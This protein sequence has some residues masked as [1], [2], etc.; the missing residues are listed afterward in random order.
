MC[1]PDKRFVKRFCQLKSFFHLPEKHYLH[2]LITTSHKEEYCDS[3]LSLEIQHLLLIIAF[4]FFWQF[5]SIYGIYSY[6]FKK[7]LVY[8]KECPRSK[9]NQ[10]MHFGKMG[11]FVWQIE[12][13]IVYLIFK[14]NV[15]N[16]KQSLIENEIMQQCNT[17]SF[18]PTSRAKL[19][20]S[21]IYRFMHHSVSMYKHKAYTGVLIT[22]W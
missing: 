4:L 22:N 6:N 7:Y 5:F 20:Q 3:K 11:H 8:V 2:S 19:I 14:N 13:R 9:S 21:Q 12:S 18:P 10:N 16:L 15:T 1:N 17:T